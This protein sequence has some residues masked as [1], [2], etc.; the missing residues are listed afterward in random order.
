MRI[1]IS[2]SQ[3]RL[4]LTPNLTEE[5]TQNVANIFNTRKR[6][7][8]YQR[9]MGIDSRVIDESIDVVMMYYQIEMSRQ[10]KQYEP[11][12]IIKKFKWNESDLLSGDLV[13]DVE[14]EIKDSYL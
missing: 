3:S 10:V 12:V 11:R 9:S 6:S 7:I 2:T 13:A 5:V 1:T 4:N 8:P 14:I